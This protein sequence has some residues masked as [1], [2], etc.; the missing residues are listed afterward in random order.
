MEGSGEAKLDA[1]LLFL[2]INMHSSLHAS[3]I[4]RDFYK[5]EK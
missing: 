3:V 5:P 2:D 1:P 4:S